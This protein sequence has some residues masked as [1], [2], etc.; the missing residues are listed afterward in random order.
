MAK[1]GE[2]NGRGEVKVRY[3]TDRAQD[4]KGDEPAVAAADARKRSNLLEGSTP[5]FI[6]KSHKIFYTK[7]IRLDTH[8]TFAVSSLGSPLLPVQTPEDLEVGKMY[9][10]TTC[11]RATR[12]WLPMRTWMISSSWPASAS[13]VP[14]EQGDQRTEGILLEALIRTLGP[15]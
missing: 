13:T 11:A 7:Q 2:G 15:P 12:G 10:S 1:G 8:R 9:Q 4:K 3:K 14:L 5:L 6:D